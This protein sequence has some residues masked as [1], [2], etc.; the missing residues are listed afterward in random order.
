MKK[1]PVRKKG[2]ARMR[3]LGRNGVTIWLTPEQVNK[4]DQARGNLP[5]ATWSL[6]MVLHAIRQVL[7]TQKGH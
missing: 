1:K 3:Q 2:P 6:A 7:Q 4:L 5:R